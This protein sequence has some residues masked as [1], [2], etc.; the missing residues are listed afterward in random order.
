[1]SSIQTV[2][3]TVR[4][5]ALPDIPVHTLLPLDRYDRIMV[6]LSGGKDSIACVLHLI[7]LGYRHKI[8]LWHQSVD[9]DHKTAE[10]FMDW[11]ITPGYC[12]AFALA[13]GLPLRYQWKQGGFQREMAR[14]N[15]PTAPTA[16]QL[17]DG[18]TRTVGGAGRPGTRLKFPQ[19]SADLK[20]RWCS[21]YLK[22]DVA[23]KGV[24]NDPRFDG[25]SFLYVTGERREESPARAKY[26]QT[27]PHRTSGQRRRVDHWRPVI[28]W[29]EA[30]VWAIL[31][32]HRI[33]PHPCYRLGWGRCSCLACI[34]GNDD[35]WASVRDLAPGQFAAIAACEQR[36]GVTIHRRRSVVERADAG[37]SYVTDKPESL[38]RL[39]MQSRYPLD[40]LFVA[41]WKL[42]AGAFRQDGGPS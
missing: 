27:E 3:P 38:K 1:M 19:V 30:E 9:G 42:P 26:R 11:P 29:P 41:D 13:L 37:V 18:R 14:E 6:S 28:D 16:V 8:E 32:R 21:A 24:T 15:Q 25:G 12:H 34:F 36:F 22:I 39:A 23:A 31:E 5:R 17:S 7:E 33:N 20:V 4:G 40:D 35:Q 2:E 10:P